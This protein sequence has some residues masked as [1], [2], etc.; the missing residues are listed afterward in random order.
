MRRGAHPNRQAATTTTAIATRPCH[1][2]TS[3]SVM[4]GAK[5]SAQTQKGAG[6]GVGEWCKNRR[7]V[8]CAHEHWRWGGRGGGGGGGGGGGA[9]R[10]VWFFGAIIEVG[11][12]VAH[13]I[14]GA[15]PNPPP[16][17]PPHPTPPGP[18]TITK[19]ATQNKPFK[20]ESNGSCKRIM[21]SI[22]AMMRCAV[23]T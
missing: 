20:K 4:L 3:S 13:R 12:F 1:A 14:G 21:T 10:M 6:E 5:D 18:P 2:P 11:L 19:T 9:R 7:G 22:E 8:V 15:P 23:P 17:T 16:P